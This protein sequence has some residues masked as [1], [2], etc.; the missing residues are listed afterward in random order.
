[1]QAQ[2]A[3]PVWQYL[4]RREALARTLHVLD[5]LWLLLAK[6]QGAAHLVCESLQPLGQVRDP[7]YS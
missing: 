7:G 2:W 1:M 5:G 4:M 6:V 3:E